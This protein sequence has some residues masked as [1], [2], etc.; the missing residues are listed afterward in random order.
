MIAAGVIVFSAALAA[1]LLQTQSTNL[2]LLGA[3]LVGGIFAWRSKRGDFYK[4]V[5]EEKTEESNRL[6]ADNDR[7]RHQTDITPIID[8]LEHVASALDRVVE[9][10]EQ[11]VAK[12]GE[13][14]GSLRSHSVA[15]E[16]LAQRI[17]VD[18][19]A[20]GLLKAAAEAPEQK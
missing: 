12:V 14:N 17:V 10:S 11:V 13:M 2:V 4:A 20:R 8:R 3:V 18:E 16:A 7:L 1:S 15:M 19:A 6:R 5:A 9:M